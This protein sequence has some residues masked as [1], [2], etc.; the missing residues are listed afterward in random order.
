[1]V[2]IHRAWVLGQSFLRDTVEFLKKGIK[3]DAVRKRA[4][5][6]VFKGGNAAASASEAIPLECAYRKREALDDLFDFHVLG[7]A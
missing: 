3:V 5:L 1:V 4:F 6:D 2:F 7:D